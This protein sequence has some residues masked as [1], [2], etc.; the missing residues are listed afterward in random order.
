MLV[1][2]ALHHVFEVAGRDGV[3]ADM[4]GG[5]FD[6]HDPRQ[7][8]DATLGGA[9]PTEAEGMPMTDAIDEM[10][11]IDPLAPVAIQCRTVAWEGEQHA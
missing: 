9:G 2:C 7:L 1:G 3:H 6:G 10:L 8:I 5:E 4:R 11:M